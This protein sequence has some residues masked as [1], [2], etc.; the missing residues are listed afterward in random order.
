MD[1]A[2]AAQTLPRPPALPDTTDGAT[3]SSEALLAATLPRAK[4]SVA[5]LVVS[6]VRRCC[7]PQL[8]TIS[9]VGGLVTLGRRVAGVPPPPRVPRTL[10]S[11]RS[12]LPD[13][14]HQDPA[15][16]ADTVDTAAVEHE[17]FFNRQPREAGEEGGEQPGAEAKVVL[18]PRSGG[19]DQ[20]E[21]DRPRS[22]GIGVVGEWMGWDYKR[23]LRRNREV[24]R[25][26]DDIDDYRPYF[27]YWVTTVQLLVLAISLA[28]YGFGP[29]GV[30][31]YQGKGQVLSRGLF[32]EEVDFLE[33][34][35]FW[36]G[37]RPADLIHLGAKFSPCMRRDQAIAGEVATA[38]ALVGAAAAAQLTVSHSHI[39]NILT[40]TMQCCRRRRDQ[41]AASATTTPAACRAWPAS[42][43]RCSPRGTGGP[44]RP[45]ARTAACRGPCAARTRS[46]APRRAPA[47]PAPGGTTSPRGQVSCSTCPHVS[48]TLSIRSVPRV[49]AAPPRLLLRSELRVRGGVERAAAHDLRADRAAVL[50]RY[51]R[52]VRDQNQGVLRLCQRPL[53]PRGCALLAGGLHGGRVR[54]AALRRRGPRPDLPRVDQVR[55][56]RDLS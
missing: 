14:R 27:T 21:P 28:L 15:D 16:T 40:L 8:I 48:C 43:R 4:P 49:R 5:D 33:P 10:T 31:L 35:N 42:A 13:P 6:V 36:V 51:P 39:T 30:E 29:L 46:T 25:Q 18:R 19:R 9:Q 1:T 23:S 34:S 26:L 44:P 2:A 12:F 56:S 20:D 47:T 52:Q 3:P 22:Y 7:S 54:D 55:T 53:P 38:R 37:P 45:R 32:I 41:A 50:H 24:M 17:V 11:S